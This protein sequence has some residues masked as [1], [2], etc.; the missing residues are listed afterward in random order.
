L[1][2]YSDPSGLNANCLKL[3]LASFIPLIPNI[4]P[5]A[6]AEKICLGRCTYK[7]P[8]KPFDGPFTGGPQGPPFG[9]VPE[10]PHP[11][12][13]FNVYRSIYLDCYLKKEPE[14]GVFGGAGATIRF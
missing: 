3:C 2:P 12:K 11:F 13:S 14:G 4:F 9:G 10:P 6:W 7:S 1:P 5:A 8:D